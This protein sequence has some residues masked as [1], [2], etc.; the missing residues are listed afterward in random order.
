VRAFR[1]SSAA[2]P[3]RKRG[4]QRLLRFRRLMEPEHERAAHGR[5][6]LER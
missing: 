2:A 6:T 5:L 1:Q 3:A 4:V